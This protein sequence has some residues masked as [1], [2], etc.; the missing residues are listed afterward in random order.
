MYQ[1]TLG[2]TAISAKSAPFSCNFFGQRVQNLKTRLLC[3]C[4]LPISCQSSW[5]LLSVPDAIL[6]IYFHCA[7]KK[8]RAHATDA[9][10][11]FS[12][13][14][15]IIRCSYKIRRYGFA[16]S[17]GVITKFSPLRP[18]SL[19]RWIHFNCKFCE[20]RR[21]LCV[22]KEIG[23]EKIMTAITRVSLTEMPL[24]RSVAALASIVRD[25]SLRERCSR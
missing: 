15:W 25:F 9:F 16:V 18:R 23:N 1:Y 7:C 3:L 6:F 21:Q 5:R 12:A 24:N 22:L 13:D 10:F 11:V 17:G 2:C 19:G 4:T 14:W 20:R 8:P